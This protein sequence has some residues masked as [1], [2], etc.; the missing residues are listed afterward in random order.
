MLYIDQYELTIAAACAGMNSQFTLVAVGLLYVYVVRRAE[1]RYALLLA[2]L[3]IPIAI[4]AN[5]ARILLLMLGMHYLGADAVAP[6]SVL[7]ESA[8]LF[9]FL[10]SLLGLIGL[11]LLLTSIRRSRY[12]T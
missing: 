7:H 6:D 8:G 9:M 1:W 3:S 5:L 4:I 12:A 11:D 10:V 2:M